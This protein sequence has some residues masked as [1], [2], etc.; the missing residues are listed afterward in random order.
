VNNGGSA[1]RTLGLH[2][3]AEINYTAWQRWVTSTG[4]SWYAAGQEARRRMANA[5]FDIGAGDT[6]AVNEFSSAVRANTGSARQNI[7]DLVRGLYD[8]DGSQQQTKGIVFVVG[9]SQDG[10]SVAQYKA[11]LESWFQDQNLWNDRN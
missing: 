4:N 11:N 5:G 6:W 8:G 10:V 3:A 7:R 9:P 2:A 1:V